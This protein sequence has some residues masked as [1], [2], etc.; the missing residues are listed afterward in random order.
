[1]LAEPKRTAMLWALMDGSVKSSEELAVLTGLSAASANAHLARLTASGLLLTEARRGKRLFRV[2]A[3]DVSAAIDALASTTM[4]S[5]ARSRPSVSPPALVA[6][7]L[8]RRARLCHGHLG[9]ELAA[10]LYQ[11]MLAAGWIERHEQR[12]EVTVKGAQCLADLGI[13]TQALASP[14]VCDCFDWSQP[15]PH[16]GGALGVG[17]LQLFLQSNW[18]S[19][20]NEFRALLVNDVGL[21]HILLIAAPEQP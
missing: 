21:A 20:I 8:L 5:A 9:G 13:F 1:M 16:L 14:L 4:A 2:A 3:A 15:Q 7:P 10:G 19:V 17:L 12:I 11:R 18:I 6:P